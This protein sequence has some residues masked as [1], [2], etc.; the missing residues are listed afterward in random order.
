MVRGRGRK[1]ERERETRR[2]TS[3]G[4]RNPTRTHHIDAQVTTD[5]AWC[6]LTWL[7]GPQHDAASRHGTHALPDHAAD[8]ATA[9]VVDEA[10]EE[11]AAGQ[12]SVVGLEVRARGREELQRLQLEALALKSAR[13]GGRWALFEWGMS[14]L[15]LGAPRWLRAGSAGARSSGCGVGPCQTA[16]TNLYLPMI[17]PS[18]PRCTPSGLT[19][20]YVRWVGSR[21][22]EGRGGGRRKGGSRTNDLE[23]MEVA[24]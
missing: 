13:R 19:I 14:G 10:G 9:H 24:D 11:A 22:E 15:A 2:G 16:K 8:G 7:G 1:R 18:R 12:V 23:K 17:S 3:D 21:G 5:G 4:K 20:M 6:A